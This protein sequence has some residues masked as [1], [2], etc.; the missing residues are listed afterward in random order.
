MFKLSDMID[1]TLTILCANQQCFCLLRKTCQGKNIH[2][3]TYT[4]MQRVDCTVVLLCVCVMSVLK[5]SYVP[6]LGYQN[7][8]GCSY[9][10]FLWIASTYTLSRTTEV[11]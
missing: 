10:F 2:N 3:Y 1:M 4:A 6:L 8:S 9:S 11:L 7:S 5:Q